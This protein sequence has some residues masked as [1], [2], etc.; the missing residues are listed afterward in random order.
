MQ[1]TP[2]LY[3]DISQLIDWKLNHPT[4]IQRVVC[5]VILQLLIQERQ[6]SLCACAKDGNI[7]TLDF[8]ATPIL[9]REYFV[10]SGQAG[11]VYM[12]SMKSE[13]LESRQ[14]QNSIYLN[15]DSTWVTNLLPSLKR[16][17][18]SNAFS[19]VSMVYDVTPCLQPHWRT[20]FDA[21]VFMYWA[22]Q[23]L[24]MSH[25]ILTISEFSK[26]EIFKYCRKRSIQE[27]RIDVVRLG[28]LPDSLLQS[29][30]NPGALPRRAVKDEF[31]LVVGS[32]DPR[33]N[34]KLVYDAWN[35]P[36]EM[37]FKHIPSVVFAGNMMHPDMKSFYHEVTSNPET[38]RH[39]YLINSPSDWELD[40]YYKNCLAT[41]Y[42]SVYEGWGLPVAESLCYGKITFA[43]NKSSIPEIESS[44]ITFIESNNPKDL[45]GAILKFLHDKEWRYFQ[46]SRIRSRFRPW[47]WHKTAE[48]I[49]N[50]LDA[51]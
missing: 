28:D 33:K 27:P 44:L 8:A 49:T 42:P 29:I 20:P 2:H 26:L 30:D 40:W 32:L 6:F 35:H 1:T 47:R 45:A 34:H 12:Q 22:D 9:L 14:F 7:H 3:V 39:F 41:I 21:Q 38:S 4:G 16:I 51:S 37:G 43:L 48:Q 19:L 18:K 13:P 50:L 23:V 24:Q 11:M 46:E 25:R 5:E 36:L 31:F 17:N 15:L 10:K